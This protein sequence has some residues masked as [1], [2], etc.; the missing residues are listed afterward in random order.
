MSNRKNTK[1]HRTPETRS[2]SSWL[3]SKDAYETLCVSGYTRLDRV[4]AIVAGYRRIAEL[5]GSITIHLMENTSDGDIR[6]VNELSRKIDIEP[7]KRMSRSNWTEF[8]LMTMFIYGRGN[9]IVKVKTSGGY[10][11]DMQPIPA[12]RFQLI[13]DTTGYDYSVMIDG[14]EFSPDDVLHFVYNPDPYYPWRGQGVTT[15]LKDLGDVLRQAKATEKGFM[16]S[17]WKPSLIV[18]VD[19]LTEEFSSPN[20]RKKLLEDYISTGSAGEPWMIPAD[21]ID[22]K[23]IRPLSLSDLALNDSVQ[24]DTKQVAALIGVPSFVLGIGDYKKVEW[25][26]FIQTK[27]RPICIMMAQELTKKLIYSPKWYVKYNSLSL[28]DYD[29]EAIAS[30]FEGLQDR[31]DVCGNEVRDHIGLSPVEGLN[32]YK[33]LENYIPIDMSGYQKKLVQKGANDE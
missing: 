17:K 18:K 24:L 11:E 21:T 5:I 20:G 12:S 32:E 7:C 14:V 33:V 23:E 16:E 2:S 30:V 6:I 26:S 1:N 4:P 19:A 31:G 10:L 9:S 28:M 27:I 8:I 3:V 13:P 22:V 15:T 25:N 29:I